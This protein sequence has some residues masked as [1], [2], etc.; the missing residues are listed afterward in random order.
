MSENLD[1]NKHDTCFVLIIFTTAGVAVL[2]TIITYFSSPILTK[3]FGDG[4]LEV[5]NLC[6]KQTYLIYLEHQGED[7]EDWAYDEEPA[8]EEV[9]TNFYLDTAFISQPGF[10]AAGW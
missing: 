8:D 5:G 9:A 4:S 6:Y 3:I 10:P 1:L 7:E 2:L